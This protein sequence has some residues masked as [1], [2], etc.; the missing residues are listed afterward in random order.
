MLMLRAEE[1]IE[2]GAE[3]VAGSWR[4]SDWRVREREGQVGWGGRR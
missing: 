3:W 2:G 4:R 1:G